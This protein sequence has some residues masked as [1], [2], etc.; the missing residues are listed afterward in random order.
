MALKIVRIILCCSLLLITLEICIRVDQKLTYGAPLL[1]PYNISSMLTYDQ[2]GVRG[3]PFGQY[4]RF[5]LNSLGYRSPETRWDRERIVSIGASETFGLTESDGMEYPRQLE[6]SLN[7]RVRGD[8]YQVLNVAFPGQSI[9]TAAKRTI[10]VADQIQPSVAL[11][12]PSFLPYFDPP[13]D[14][15]EPV[16]W[17]KPGSQ[18]ELRLTAKFFELLDRLPPSV[19]TARYRFHIW[20]ATRAAA[21]QPRVPEINVR[22]FHT[23]LGALLDRLQERRIK[24]I[25]VTHAT[26]FGQ[27]VD[28]EERHMLIAWRRFEPTLAEDGFLDVEKRMNRVMREEANSRGV[29]LVDAENRMDGHENF[30]DWVHFTDLGANR[31]AQ[32]ITDKVV[33]NKEL[34]RE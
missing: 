4:L 5:R 26:Y 1:R 32:I 25:L 8:H 6:R 20:K 22:R 27:S 33:A 16:D 2:V 15:R 24:P 21:I 28:P 11:I 31:M 9:A 19:T 34:R 30:S 17:V 29:D 12:Y 13:A 23:D 14:S 18:P 3:R 10:E 7:Q